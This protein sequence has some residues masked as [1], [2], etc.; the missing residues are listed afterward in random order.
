MFGFYHLIYV[1]LFMF[2]ENSWLDRRGNFF[3]PNKHVFLN[4]SVYIFK[5][6]FEKIL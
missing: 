1:I 3:F 2:N 5:F 4:S 6:T